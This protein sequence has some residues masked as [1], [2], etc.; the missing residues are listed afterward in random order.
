MMLMVMATASVCVC[1][2]VDDDSVNGDDGVKH[3]SDNNHCLEMSIRIIRITMDEHTNHRIVRE[4]I[5]KV[6]SLWYSLFG[7]LT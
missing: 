6:M 7:S 3:D 4:T 1:V 2:C 5:L